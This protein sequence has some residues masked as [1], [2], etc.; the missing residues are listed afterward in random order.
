MSETAELV[1]SQSQPIVARPLV[2]MA[3]MNETGHLTLAWDPEDD[4]KI[5]PAIQRL[6]DANHVFWIVERNPLREEELEDADDL[7]AN[8]HVIIK[9]EELEALFRQGI[10]SIARHDDAP[11]ERVRRATTAE[12]V[13]HNDTVTHRPLAGG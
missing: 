7:R 11:L 8:R 2:T 10:L 12:E 13:A 3:V 1:Q 6:M 5:I 4:E 9:N